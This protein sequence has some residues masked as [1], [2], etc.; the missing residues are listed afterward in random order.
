MAIGILPILLIPKE[1]ADIVLGGE[2]RLAR[3]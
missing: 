1:A 3:D 2:E